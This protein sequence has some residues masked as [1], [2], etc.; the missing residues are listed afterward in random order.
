MRQVI[1]ID[2]EGLKV[3]AEIKKAAKDGQMEGAKIL[4]REV[5]SRFEERW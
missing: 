5:R 4:A 2:R 3:K 1:K